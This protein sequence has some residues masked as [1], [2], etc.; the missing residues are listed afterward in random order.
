MIAGMDEAI[1]FFE[2]FLEAEYQTSYAKLTEPDDKKFRALV[3]A[4]D[5]MYEGKD[6]RSGASRIA[7]KPA[8]VYESEENRKGVAQLRRRPLFAVARYG[9]VYRAWVGGDRPG[10][11]GEIMFTSYYA[12]ARPGGFKLI[13]RYE[14]CYHC[15]GSG[16]ENGAPCSGCGGNGWMYR[17]GIH[18]EKLGKITEAKK[19]QAPT[20]E[21]SLQGYE[22]IKAGA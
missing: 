6:F 7:N 20:D 12:Q 4:L 5:A 8:S 18:A 14:V 17:G 10:R 16:M 19:L 13:G 2:R 9:D 3:T 11:K 22:A 15:T 1:T 21:Q